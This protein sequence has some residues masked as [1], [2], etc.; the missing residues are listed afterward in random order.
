MEWFGLALRLK[1]IISLHFDDH[2]GERRWYRSR[3]AT[4][5]D[6]E[7]LTTTSFALADP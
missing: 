6:Q 2:Y 4:V 3:P 1:R 7:K 5:T